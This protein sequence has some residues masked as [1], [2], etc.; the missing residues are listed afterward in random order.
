MLRL[1]SLLCGLLL[2]LP[3]V[4]QEQRIGQI[5]VGQAAGHRVGLQCAAGG[6]EHQRQRPGAGDRARAK[7]QGRGQPALDQQGLRH[8]CAQHLRRGVDSGDRRL[9]ADGL[10][11]LGSARP[12][13]GAQ[14]ES[15]AA[16]AVA[17][18]TRGQPGLQA[19]ELAGI[20]AQLDDAA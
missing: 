12:Q 13:R 4:A 11:G 20:G 7:D 18:L 14:L 17:Q 8:R 9:A 16:A 10:A 5:K 2:A 6:A 15:R 3:A 1:A 19:G